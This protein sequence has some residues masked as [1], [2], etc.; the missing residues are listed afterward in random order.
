MSVLLAIAENW[1]GIL[2]SSNLWNLWIFTESGSSMKIAPIID[3]IHAKSAKGADI[4]FRLIH[5]EQHCNIG[6][7]IARLFGGEWKKGRIPEKWNDQAAARIM[8]VLLNGQL[9]EN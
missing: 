1:Q 8:D 5:T 7:A 3:A 2:K 9:P 4:C 6:P